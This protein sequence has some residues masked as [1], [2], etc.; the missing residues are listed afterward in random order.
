MNTIKNICF[1]SALLVISSNSYSSEEKMTGSKVFEHGTKIHQD[2]C[3]KCHTDKIYTRDTSFVKSIN[4]LGQQVK[5]CK[6]GNNIPWFDEDTDA[7]VH[8]LNQK[9]YKF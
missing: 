2:H 6:D 4:A 3:Y 1:L 7:V 5:R 9:Y 8:F